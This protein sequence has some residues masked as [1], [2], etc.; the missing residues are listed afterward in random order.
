[1]KMTEKV[2]WVKQF[3]EKYEK[4]FESNY[5]EDHKW[6]ITAQHSEK[7]AWVILVRHTDNESNANGFM[8]WYDM[9]PSV[10]VVDGKVVIIEEFS[11]EFIENYMK[12]NK[13]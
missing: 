10:S 12:E 11:K 6:T 13:K 4:H 3:I 1:M 7:D 8:L 5:V 2:E 9:Y